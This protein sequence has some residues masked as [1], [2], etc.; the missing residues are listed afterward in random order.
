MKAPKIA[1]H[2]ARITVAGSFAALVGLVLAGGGC[3]QV[4]GSRCNPALSHD[5]CD[6]APTTQCVAPTAAACNGE[7]YCCTVDSNGNITDT[8]DLNCQFLIACQQASAAE[9]GTGDD[10]GDATTMEAAAAE[11]STPETGP[12]ASPD[13]GPD[14]SPDVA[15]EAAPDVSAEASLEDA[16]GGG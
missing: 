10:G 6:S 13:A 9:S 8:T 5:E 15:A 16:G 1:S 7:A 11:T 12:D 3:S 14:A 4:E 2:W